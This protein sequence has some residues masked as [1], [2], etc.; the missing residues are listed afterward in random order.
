MQAL[1]FRSPVDGTALVAMLA[2]GGA[3]GGLQIETR[4]PE[5]SV[6]EAT[7]DWMSDVEVASVRRGCRT[8]R[9]AAVLLRQAGAYGIRR[10]N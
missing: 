7:A 6:G 10:D 5:R 2:A 9:Q 1:R 8:L 4:R 3:D